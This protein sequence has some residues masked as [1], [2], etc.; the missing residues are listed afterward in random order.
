M[1]ERPQREGNE[2]LI[3]MNLGHVQTIAGLGRLPSSF[4]HQGH[5]VPL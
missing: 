2:V 1:E 4:D 5:E 3:F